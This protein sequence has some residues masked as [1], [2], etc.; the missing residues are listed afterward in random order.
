MAEDSVAESAPMLEDKD[1]RVD[2]GYPGSGYI[3]D[4]DERSSVEGVMKTATGHEYSLTLRTFNEFIGT[5]VWIF[6]ATLATVQILAIQTTVQNTAVTALGAYSVDNTTGTITNMTEYTAVHGSYAFFNQANGLRVG[7][8][9]LTV[10]DNPIATPMVSFTWAALFYLVL[11]FLPGTSLNPWVS[12]C[13]FWF[14]WKKNGKVSLAHLK[15][16]L[17]ETLLAIGGQFAGGFVA[18]ICV[19]FLFDTDTSMLGETLPGP[20]L[21]NDAKVILYEAVGSFLFM[22]A[23]ALYSRPRRNVSANQQAGL[24]ST[25]LFFLMLCFFGFTGASLNFVRTFSPALVRTIFSAVPI[26][27]NVLYY[28]LGQGIGFGAAG[29]LCWFLNTASHAKLFHAITTS[30][31]YD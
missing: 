31:K 10:M 26:R 14:A 1:E 28:L 19:Y 27:F 5:F 8:G 23:I 16:L 4:G 25:A 30:S 20:T 9:D 13:H 12:L 3:P 7:M 24:I 11:S 21:N 17:M 2:A 22:L 15:H 29:L 18:I 6:L